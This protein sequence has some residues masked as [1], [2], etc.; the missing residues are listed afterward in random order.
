M[1]GCVDGRAADGGA[2]ARAGLRRALLAARYGAS[3]ATGNAGAGGLAVVRRGAAQRLASTMPVGCT[4]APLS[5][6][7]ASAMSTA[8]PKTKPKT[9]IVPTSRGDGPPW[10]PV[11]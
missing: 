8:L 2:G 11:R 5:S 4:L 1:D 3:S 10:T 6:S 7:S 9:T